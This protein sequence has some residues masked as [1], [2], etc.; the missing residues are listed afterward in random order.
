M[1]KIVAQDKEHRASKN[2]RK[3][4]RLP[5]HAVYITPCKDWEWVKTRSKNILTLTQ[6]KYG[7]GGRR[8][9]LGIENC[10]LNARVFPLGDFFAVVSNT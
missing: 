4:E 7:R 2:L 3:A 10:S 5:Q 6:K 1:H 9:K 8:V